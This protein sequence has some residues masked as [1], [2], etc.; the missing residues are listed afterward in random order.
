MEKG[1]PIP[2]IYR[3]FPNFYLPLPPTQ[4]PLSNNFQAITQ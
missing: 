2:Y 4:P 3:V 1:N